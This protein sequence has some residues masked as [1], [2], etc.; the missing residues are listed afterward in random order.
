[1]SRAEDGP[2]LLELCWVAVSRIW[3]EQDSHRIA[4]PRG[5]T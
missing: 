3:Y 1:M 4:W 5:A 2:S